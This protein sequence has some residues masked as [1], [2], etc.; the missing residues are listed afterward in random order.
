M[1]KYG[2]TREFI[3]NR[4]VL[5]DPYMHKLSHKSCPPELSIHAKDTAS[6]VALT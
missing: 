3:E 5:F 2:I 1:L 6:E 4:R